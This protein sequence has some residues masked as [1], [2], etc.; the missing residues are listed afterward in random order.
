MSLKPHPRILIRKTILERLKTDVDL[1]G[2]WFVSRSV[3]LWNEELPC[4]LLYTP[5]EPARDSAAVRPKLIR[6][7]LRVVVQVLREFDPESQEI[8]DEYFDSRCWEI[9]KSVFKDFNLGIDFVEG[10]NLVNTIPFTVSVEGDNK[11]ASCEISFDVVYIFEAWDEGLMLD[12]FLRFDSLYV[13]PSG[14]PN[15]EDQVT[16]R[17]A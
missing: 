12:E 4:G 7:E 11:Y 16:I 6:R 2:R 17:E 8:L 15:A 13:K 1:G 14:D 5:N 9:E 10:V 3:P